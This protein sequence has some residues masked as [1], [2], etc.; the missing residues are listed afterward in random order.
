MKMMLVENLWRN[1]S[2]SSVTVHLNALI[3]NYVK[4]QLPVN[5]WRKEMSFSEK[6]EFVR[7]VNVTLG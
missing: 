6:V 4:R 2:R 3:L 1:I 5:S 7:G